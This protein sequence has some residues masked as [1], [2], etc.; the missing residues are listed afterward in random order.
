MVKTIKVILSFFFLLIAISPA[1]AQTNELP[2]I[3]EAWRKEYNVPG[4]SVGIIKDGEIILSEGFGVLEEGKLKKADQHTLYAIAS[5][6]KA[7]IS[8]SIATL[9]KENKLQWND[10]VRKYLPYFQLYDPC[11]SE[12][13]TIRD[14][15]CHRSGLG[16]FSGDVVW[17]RSEYTAEEVVRRIAELEPQ[18]EFRNGYGYSNVMYLAAGE[19]IQAVTGKTWAEYVQEKFITP[20][21]MDRTL[22][23]INGFS[24]TSN[25]ATPHKF[26]Q[27]KNIPIDWVE[28]DNMGAAG[29][30]IS[31]VDDML[32]WIRF[33]LN[34]GIIGLDTLFTNREQMTMWTPHVNFPVSER[35]RELYGGRNFSGY[36]LGWGTSEYNGYQMVSHTGG[37]DGMYSAVMLLPTKNIG[38]VVLT[39]SMTSIGSLLGYEIFDK[40]LGLPQHGWKERG[41]WQD[42]AG[43]DDR[44]A[45]IKERT[46]SRILGTTPTMQF[47]KIAGTYR[48]PMYGDITIVE[49]DGQW[50]IDFVSAPG[51]KAKLIH[52]HF[53]TYS[54]EWVEDQAW[55]GFGT[56]QILKDNNGHPS[57]L[58]FDVPNDDI[59]FEEIKAVRLTP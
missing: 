45:K 28:W 26:E 37:Y 21:E 36:G 2:S 10:P 1:D 48:C 52:W 46:D 31:S 15:L 39:N 17:Y 30:I 16:T 20:L 9:V 47:D 6:T 22:T 12:M 14:L 34:D 40:L 8:A 23:S 4:L 29:G 44:A 13:M 7:F 57:G 56:V 11:V 3:I 55:F 42:Q 43:I 27:E 51:L 41:L 25:I 19:V 24:T 38:V 32:H 59:F 50:M 35:S 49:E 58:S 33:Q 18:F 54:L 53:D 5:N